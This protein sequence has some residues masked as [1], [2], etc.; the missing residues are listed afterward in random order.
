VELEAFRNGYKDYIRK[1]QDSA[2]AERTKVAAL[3]AEN[4]KLKADFDAAGNYIPHSQIDGDLRAAKAEAARW[5]EALVH[6]AQDVNDPAQFA[7]ATLTRF[8]QESGQ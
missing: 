5:R 6:I 7:R 2:E 8:D 3:E 1:L 4:A